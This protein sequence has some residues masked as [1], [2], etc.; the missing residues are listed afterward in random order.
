MMKKA[1]KK[2]KLEKQDKHIFDLPEDILK[3]IF[4][5]V[6]PTIKGV[7]FDYKYYFEPSKQ[8]GNKEYLWMCLYEG[9]GDLKKA[10]RK[11]MKTFITHRKVSTQFKKYIDCSLKLIGPSI[12]EKIIDYQICYDS[13][14]VDEYSII[15][16]YCMFRY[17]SL[18]TVFYLSKNNIYLYDWLKEVNLLDKK[19]AISNLG[20]ARS[21]YTCIQ[22]YNVL[23]TFLNIISKKSVNR[24]ISPYFNPVILSLLK[25]G[26]IKLPYLF[27]MK[28]HV[29]RLN[30]TDLL[31][32]RFLQNLI[33]CADFKDE[34]RYFINDIIKLIDKKTIENEKSKKILTKLLGTEDIIYPKN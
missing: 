9:D 17:I 25:E 6:I 24:I 27:T 12:I 23:F 33:D 30:D 11:S 28:Y 19:I 29:F 4:S 18:Y 31:S 16:I 1:N 13:N 21:R 3:I 7:N 26:I 20:F 2:I 5:Y 34:D 32:N 8:I 15:F 14:N 22:I 10:F